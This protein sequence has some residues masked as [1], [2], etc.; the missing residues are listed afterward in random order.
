MRDERQ[1]PR[2][3]FN[4]QQAASY[5]SL[6]RRTLYAYCSM[7]IMPHIKVGRR[8]LFRKSDLDKWLADPL[9]PV[10]RQHGEA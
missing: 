5:T 6:A 10:A 9:V 3:V 1:I 8:L 7:R 2:Q 4:I